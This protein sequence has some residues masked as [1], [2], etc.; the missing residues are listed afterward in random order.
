MFRKV[1][2]SGTER[3]FLLACEGP[4][5]RV[6]FGFV[7]AFPAGLVFFGTYPRAGNPASL[8]ASDH[9]ADR[10]HHQT[11]HQRL[12]QPKLDQSCLM[13]LGDRPAHKS[14]PDKTKRGKFGR[15]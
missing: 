8:D 13:C 2:Q 7:T 12:D 9:A 6:I 1:K 10:R 14:P 11:A 5:A 4:F 15:R 3:P